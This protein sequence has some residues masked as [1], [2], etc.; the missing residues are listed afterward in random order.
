MNCSSEPG[1]IAAGA[2]ALPGA[3]RRCEAG[4][5]VTAAATRTCRALLAATA[6][7]AMAAPAQAQTEIFRSATLTVARTRASERP[8]P[9]LHR[10]T[11]GLPTPAS[12]SD[13]DFTLGST[14]RAI[15]VIEAQL[16]TVQM[17]RHLPRR[18]PPLP[19]A[20]H[21]LS[22]FLRRRFHPRRRE[23]WFN[24]ASP[25][26]PAPTS[27]SGSLRDGPGPMWTYTIGA[28]LFR[29]RGSGEKIENSRSTFDQPTVTGTPEFEFCLAD[30]HG[31]L[32]AQHVRRL[33]APRRAAR[34]RRRSCSAVMVGDVA[35][36]AS[37]PADQALASEPWHHPCSPPEE[38]AQTDH[39]GQRAAADTT[40]PEVE[41]V[42]LLRLR[43]PTRH[44][45]RRDRRWRLLDQRLLSHRCR[46]GRA[47]SLTMP[48]GEV[49]AVPVCANRHDQAGCQTVVAPA[50]PIPPPA[51]T[52]Y[53]APGLRVATARRL[54][55]DRHVGHPGESPTSTST[56]PR[57]ST[58]TGLAARPSTGN[59]RSTSPGPPT[60]APPR[61]QDR[62]LP[63]IP[64]SP[65]RQH[66][67]HLRAHRP[68]GDHPRQR[69]GS[70]PHPSGT[71]EANTEANTITAQT[72]VL[73]A[74]RLTGRQRRRGAI[75]ADVPRR[76]PGRR[77]RPFPSPLGSAFV[78]HPLTR[79]A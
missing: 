5:N 66:H 52:P 46:A 39:Q 68:P 78:R 38:G 37:R 35:T 58:P 1:V 71:D 8:R 34:A 17:D 11:A 4:T 75:L 44:R 18:R 73:A 28:G 56:T 54:L 45:G 55:H 25:G 48:Y 69:R 67:H 19:R 7:L 2:G 9:R 15:G 43:G 31:V 13:D 74:G 30:V 64:R 65:T 29:H 70:R 51:T 60:A 41:R 79:R 53:A 21:H 32:D 6:L 10:N 27:A 22:R 59:S 3:R 40:P 49:G 26:P 14:G 72:R 50:T 57:P 77:P 16:P 76:E 63:R 42:T 61:L 36:A 47:R 24:T 23:T 20:G 33:G 62:G 12:C